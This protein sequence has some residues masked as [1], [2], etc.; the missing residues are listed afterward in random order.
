MTTAGQSV[1]INSWTPREIS[2]EAYE[3]F[4]SK[5]PAD[6]DISPGF[7]FQ[8][9]VEANGLIN[10]YTSIKAKTELFYLTARS[11]Y[12]RTYET[13]SIRE[14]DKSVADGQRRA[15]AQKE[16]I[17][18]REKRDFAETYKIYVEDLIDN[19][20]RIFYLMKQ[21]HSEGEKEQERSNY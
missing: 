1:S 4:N 20:K 5:I 21:R 19:L 13:A 12:R 2:L 17:Q 16:V 6:G 8:L 7:A 18:A 14:N 10:Y 9:A 3:K 15:S 11:E